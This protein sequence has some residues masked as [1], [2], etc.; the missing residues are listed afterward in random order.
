MV[1]IL[2]AA[3]G[4]GLAGLFR[5]LLLT[6]L[7]RSR[8]VAAVAFVAIVV[9]FIAAGGLGARVDLTLIPTIS[10]VLIQCVGA[11]LLLRFGLLPAILWLASSFLLR[12]WS[13]SFDA[14]VPYLFSSYLMLGMTVALAIYGLHTALGSRSIFGA[15]FLKDEPAVR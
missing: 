6:V 14:S 10:A 15:G 13:F 4:F 5:L 7:L 9:V 1:S 12:S 11:L 3:V 2:G 8:R